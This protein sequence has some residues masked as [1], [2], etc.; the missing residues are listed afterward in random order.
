MRYYLTLDKILIFHTLNFLSVCA[1]PKFTGE[2]CQISNNF[3]S[4]PSERCHPLNTLH[5]IETLT[6]NKCV[7]KPRFTGAKCEIRIDQCSFLRPCRSGV[8]VNQGDA[9]DYKCLDCA[10][11]Y[12]GKN[13]STMINFCLANPCHNGGLCFNKPQGYYCQCLTEGYSGLNC[14][15]RISVQCLRNKCQHGSVCEPS[16]SGGYKCVNCDYDKYEGVYCDRKRDACKGLSCEYG[17]CVDGECL[18]DP[19][20]PFCRKYSECDKSVNCPNGAT[21][22]D[23]VYVGNAT[24]SYCLCPPGLTGERCERSV[25]CS[26]PNTFPCQ[27]RD[28]CRTVNGEYQCVCHEPKIGHGCNKSKMSLGFCIS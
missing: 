4:L 13:C 7:C 23:R 21:C 11:G 9:D 24:K 3:C 26:A 17:Y 12:D 19:K 14:E 25:Y 10:P 16:G 18:C 8:C 20:I 28:Q 27:T 6:G 15:Q 22:I 2:N 1:T 5:C